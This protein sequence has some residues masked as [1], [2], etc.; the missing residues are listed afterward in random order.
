MI[1][2]RDI[3]D[4]YQESSFKAGF[5]YLNKVLTDELEAE[6]FSREVMRRVQSL[7]KK[8]GLQKSDSIVLFIKAED[9]LVEMLKKH[10]D[11]IK[12][13]VGASKM[14]ISDIDPAKKHEFNAKEKVKGKTFSLWLDKVWFSW[15]YPI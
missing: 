13:K 10:E 3:P 14:K 1:V 9:E 11:S 6:G 4:K 8:S 12:D 15:N 7:R 2:E 5:I